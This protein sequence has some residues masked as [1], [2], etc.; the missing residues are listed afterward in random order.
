[1]Y[2]TRKTKAWTR[3][4]WYPHPKRMKII[5]MADSSKTSLNK[6]RFRVSKKIS[7]QLPKR[8]SHCALVTLLLIEAQSPKARIKNKHAYLPFFSP[9]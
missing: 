5:G 2:I 4:G 6:N 1:M 8:P 3:S 7:K 9:F